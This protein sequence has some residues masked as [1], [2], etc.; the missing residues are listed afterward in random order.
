MYIKTAFKTVYFRF[1]L[2]FIGGAL[3]AGIVCASYWPQLESVVS[4]G[5]STAGASPYVIAMSHMGIGVLPHIVN[6]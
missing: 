1:G 6:A 4:G 3:A 5:G 2:F